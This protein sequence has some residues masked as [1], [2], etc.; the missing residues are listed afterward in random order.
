[1]G[2]LGEQG[3]IASHGAASALSDL[4]PAGGPAG[5]ALPL[6]SV[7][8]HRAA[9]V[10]SRGRRAAQRQ[11]ETSSGVGRPGCVRRVGPAA[12]QGAANTPAG[13]PGHDPALAPSAGSCEVDLS[14][15]GRTSAC[16]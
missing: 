15:S 4:P 9:G 3:M 12:A 16:R 7:Q 14:T 13:Y 11:P 10:T 6:I 1:N 2:T 8:G 5:V